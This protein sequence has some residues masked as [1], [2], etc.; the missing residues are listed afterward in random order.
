MST[1]K[2]NKETVPM[3]FICTTLWHEE[4]NEMKTLLTSILNL[5]EYVNSRENDKDIPKNEKFNLEGTLSEN[6]LI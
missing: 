3:I 4:D 1:K 5:I 2:V 6:Y